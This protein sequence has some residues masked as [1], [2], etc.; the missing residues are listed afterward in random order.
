MTMS[1]RTAKTNSYQYHGPSGSDYLI[2]VSTRIDSAVPKT[3]PR[4]TFQGLINLLLNAHDGT[5]E[6]RLIRAVDLI[7]G[8]NG[9][10]RSYTNEKFVDQSLAELA[11][12]ALAGSGSAEM[13]NGFRTTMV[14]SISLSKFDFDYVDSG[15]FAVFIA[16]RSLVWKFGMLSGTISLALVT[17][18][19]VA[20]YRLSVGSFQK[21]VTLR[22][23]S[24]SSSMERIGSLG[25]PET[26]DD[27][28]G[29]EISAIARSAGDM[30]EQ[31]RQRNTE[32]SA[33]ARRLEEEIDAG[34]R[35][36]KALSDIRNDIAAAYGT[37]T[38]L[39][40]SGVYAGSA[41]FE[42]DT[43]M[44]TGLIAAELIDNAYRHAFPESRTGSLTLTLAPAVDGVSDSAWKLVVMDD[45]QG[46]PKTGGVGLELAG[47]LATQLGGTLSWE[48]AGGTR[49]TVTMRLA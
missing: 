37:R 40:S 18:A 44:A 14:T 7:G 31:I 10:Y 45:G 16:D 43:A 3:F 2:E 25:S 33:F 12:R 47:A 48:S 24:L 19:I 32:L 22:L 6:T 9:L 5:D 21:N 49:V 1:T 34:S 42:P 26:L 36:E 35:R 39:V 41:E 27:G 11:D 15:T 29:D 8:G 23:E 30:V 38:K 28:M 20:S 17:A 46:A 13:R 4:F